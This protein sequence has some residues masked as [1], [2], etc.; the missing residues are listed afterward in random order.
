M[1]PL[2]SHRL[3]FCLVALWARGISTRSPWCPPYSRG[4]KCHQ[5]VGRTDPLCPGAEALMSFSGVDNLQMDGTYL[6]WFMNPLWDFQTRLLEGKKVIPL[7]MSGDRVFSHRDVFVSNNPFATFP[8]LKKW[9]ETMWERNL[10]VQ[11]G[12]EKAAR[13]MPMTPHLEGTM[14]LHRAS[15]AFWH[16]RF[17]FYGLCWYNMENKSR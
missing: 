6:D 11:K 3:F 10:F 17:C 4:P 12:A 7:H 9:G 5:P 13:T 14:Q 8:E 15:S 1:P 16:P 2:Q